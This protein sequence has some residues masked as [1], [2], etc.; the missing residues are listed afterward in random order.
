MDIVSPCEDKEFK[1]PFDVQL[2]KDDKVNPKYTINSCIFN[3]TDVTNEVMKSKNEDSVDDLKNPNDENVQ[4]VIEHK[5]TLNKGINR[6]EIISQS[7][8]PI[9]DNT[10]SHSV[11]V[12]CKNYEIDFDVH[13]EAY[14]VIGFGF[15]LDADNKR[16]KGN[17]VIEKQ[18]F[19]KS[20]RIIFNEWLLPGNGC[21]FVIKKRDN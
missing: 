11:A 18:K 5:F 19:D 12:P 4:I 3:G 1:W 8:V 20:Y 16:K 13:N 14:D 9:M 10:F 15:A 2:T 17:K 21:V 6:L 7:T